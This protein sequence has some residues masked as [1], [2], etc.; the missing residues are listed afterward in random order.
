MSKKSK[1]ESDIESTFTTCWTEGQAWHYQVRHAERGFYG[2]CIQA[3]MVI[4]SRYTQT[5]DE[6]DMA[7][8][9]AIRDRNSK[10]ARLA[11]DKMKLDMW[12]EGKAKLLSS[13][14]TG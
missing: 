8:F 5:I 14:V 12:N 10:E 4:Q 3:G 7:M 13:K 6:L 9:E 11:S 2:L 1:T